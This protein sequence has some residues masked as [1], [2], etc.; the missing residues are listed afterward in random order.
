MI[1]NYLKSA[2]RNLNKNKTFSAINIMGLA[3]GMAACLLILQYVN[4]ELSWWIFA[5]SRGLL[6]NLAQH[7][8]PR[9]C[10]CESNSLCTRNAKRDEVRP[11]SHSV[12]QWLGWAG[13]L[14]GGMRW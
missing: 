9:I 3:I 4:F 8:P 14:P 10:S 2:W 5:G 7:W 1:A 11:Q 13:F 12:G 6:S